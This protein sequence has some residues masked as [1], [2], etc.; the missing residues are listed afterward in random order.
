PVSAEHGRGVSDL[1][2]AALVHLPDAP[3]LEREEPEEDTR[4]EG[5]IKLAVVGRPNVGKSTLLNR[6]IGEE[7]FVASAMPGTT[8]DAVDEQLIWKNRRYVLTDTAGLRKKRQ[9][10]DRVDVFSA[11]K[12]LRAVDKPDVVVV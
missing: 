5:P 4:P 10:V 11:Q 9:V 1:L 12:A 8:R 2:D 6:L 7:R 3:L